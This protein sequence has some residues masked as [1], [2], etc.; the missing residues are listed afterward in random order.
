MTLLGRSIVSIDD[1][2]NEEINDIFDLADALLEKGIRSARN[3]GQGRVLA[4]LFFEPSTRTRLS[5]EAAMARLGG[6]S[7]SA[8]D[9]QATSLAKGESL[10]DTVRVVSKYSDAIVLRHGWDGSAQLAAEYSEVPVINAGDGAHEHP[11]QTLCDLYTLRKRHKTLRG[12]KVALCGDLEK[13]RTIHSLAFALAR[14]KANVFFVP[15]NG[16]EIPDYMRRRLERDYSARIRRVRAGILSALFGKSED[17]EIGNQVDA[18]YMTPTEP[19][20]LS[21]I[22]QEGTTL[23]DSE[24]HIELTISG[25]EIKAL[26]VTRLQKER[27]VEGEEEDEE[28]KYPK[29]TKEVLRIPEFRDISILHPLPRVDEISPEVD[30]DAR[31]A[32]FEQAG[33]GIPIRMALLI[34]ILGLGYRDADEV[35][36]VPYTR[37][38]HG[39][40]VEPEMGI[41]CANRSCISRREP[42]FAR[43]RYEVVDGDALKLRCLYCDFEASP[44]WFGVL[45]SRKYYPIQFLHKL[46]PSLENIVFFPSTAAAVK[47]G[48][49]K[50][51]ANLGSRKAASQNKAEALI[52]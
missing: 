50:G 8:W 49:T 15:G 11:T 30:K 10:A 17:D 46:K 37:Q 13:G 25:T 34:R 9:A 48:F 40:I 47:A 22:T 4:T 18:I 42:S 20:Q 24:T 44:S 23:R 27:S 21:L 35:L 26:Y 36:R 32:Y 6:Q 43:R 33:Y 51:Q 3:L 19:N 39:K 2:S 45:K 52:Q 7:I 41:Q 38:A 28:G 29:I 12:L 1:L 5:F 16:K 14:F 31:G